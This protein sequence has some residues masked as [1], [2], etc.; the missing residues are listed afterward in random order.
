MP[1]TPQATATLPLATPGA[2]TSTDWASALPDA[3]AFVLGLA[4]ARWSGWTTGDLIWSLWLSSL[5]VGYAT[6]VWT[7]G[8]PTA[9]LLLAS[10][11]S[12][13][14]YDANPRQLL[15]LWLGAIVVAAFMLAFFTVHFG[16]FHYVHS[17]FLISFF[18]I[19]GPGIANPGSTNKA[20]YA[21]VV[22]RYW[23]FL[24]SAF[25]SHRAAFQRIPSSIDPDKVLSSF[26]WSAKSGGGFA[27]P[28]RNV[29]RMHGLIFFFFFVHF[30]GLENFAVYTVVYALYFFPWRLVRKEA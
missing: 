22:R 23:I 4:V 9:T 7:I 18:P 27:E 15:T 20:V 5:V 26:A 12:R 30:I 21:E 25:L 13:R 3:L 2:Q 19:H 10:W 11:K 14:D 17:Q 8:L 28:Y 1:I 16:G 6:I 24:P 29:M